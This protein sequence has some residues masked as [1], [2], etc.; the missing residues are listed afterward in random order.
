M[1]LTDG[2]RPAAALLAELD[3]AYHFTATGNAELLSEWL[4]LAARHG[5]RPADA[6]IRE[7]LTGVGRRKYVLPIYDALLATPE[8]AALAREIFAVARPGYHAITRGSLDA[9]LGAP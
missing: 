5:H 1:P 4:I 8:G 9:L 3:A 6:R 7:F 2:P